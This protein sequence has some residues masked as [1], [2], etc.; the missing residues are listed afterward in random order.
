M[1]S[2]QRYFLG[3]SFKGTHYAGWQIQENAVTVQQLINKA[4][5]VLIKS[6]VETTGCGRTD[7]GVHASMF[8]LHF[9]VLEPILNAK[10]FLY[11]LNA[12]L[13]SDIS[14]YSLLPVHDSAHARFDAESRT[15][16]YYISANKNPF[17]KEYTLL[18]HHPLQ[19]DSLNEGCAF[20]TGKKDFSAF[21]K[22]NTQVNS[23]VC[24]I[25]EALWTTE[26][27]LLVFTITADR[28]LRGMVRA[29]VGSLLDAGQGK[30]DPSCIMD[31]IN[32]K[33]R[34]EAGPSVPA[35]GLFL[36]QVRYAYIEN[37][38]LVKFPH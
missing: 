21:S 26:N 10:Q 18:V 37:R 25:S 8:Y 11:Q 14:V 32:S 29:I 38:I 22:S 4:I 30:A 5:S 1:A 12:I 33:S 31:I 16:K 7:A 19:I 2:Y 23:Y 28:F 17:L 9:D 36:H 15:Y 6:T 24:T 35:N 34:A 27:E 3:L 13:P 20:L